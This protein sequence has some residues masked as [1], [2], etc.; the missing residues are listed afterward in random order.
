MKAKVRIGIIGVGYWGPNLVRNFSQIEESEVV[1]VSDLSDDRL[2]YISGLHPDVRTTKNFEDIL[3]DKSIDAVVVA[4]PLET[5][6]DVARRVIDAGKHIF[7][8]KPMTRTSSEAA[9]LVRQAE[10]QNI[11]IGTGH[12]FVY[13]PAITKLKEV[14]SEQQIGIPCYAHSS[15][16]NPVPSHGNVDVIWDLAVHDISITLYLWGR[17][18]ERVRASGG[19]FV[20]GDRTDTAMLELYFPDGTFAYHHVG[21]LCSEKVRSF[22]IGGQRG[23]VV[24]DDTAKDKIRVVGSA[25]DS[26]LDAAA[27]KGHIAYNTGEVRVIELAHDEEP[28]K[29]EC[30]NFIRTIQNRERMISDGQF[31]T[32]V[33]LV[34]EA[35][36]RSIESGDVVDIGGL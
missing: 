32:E 25:V 26:R 35:A 36:S 33:V 20:H 3:K 23:S 10:K 2:E 6:F 34:L 5:H 28:L 19:R 13:H 11:K 22:F 1:W 4:T 16:M 27:Q 9:F 8:E 7:I 21:W 14:L 31:G 29:R 15:R 17:I 12:I 18:P 30:S 24:F